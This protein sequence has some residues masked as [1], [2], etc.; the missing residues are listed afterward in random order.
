MSVKEHVKSA[1]AALDEKKYDSLRI[2]CENGLKLDP[3][4]LTLLLYLG[5]ACSNLAAVRVRCPAR[6][7]HGR[8]W[9]THAIP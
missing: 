3:K 5:L 8:W 9:P 2:V 4:N 7:D 6:A 1:K